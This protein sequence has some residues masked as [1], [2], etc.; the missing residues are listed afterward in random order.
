MSMI[1]W[2][3]ETPRVS[4][5]GNYFL[6]DQPIH[7]GCNSHD[8]N[9]SGSYYQFELDAVAITNRI[10]QE[11]KGIIAKKNAV[12]AI[13]P[14]SEQHALHYVLSND[15]CSPTT[16]IPCTI[17]REY[18][19]Q[20]IKDNNT[21]YYVDLYS[22]SADCQCKKGKLCDVCVKKY[23][24]LKDILKK[25]KD[26]YHALKNEGRLFSTKQ[27][28]QDS[29]SSIIEALIKPFED[30]D[31][32]L[33]T[34]LLL[35]HDKQGNTPLYYAYTKLPG[36]KKDFKLLLDRVKLL[37]NDQDKWNLLKEAHQHNETVVHAMVAYWQNLDYEIECFGTNLI[38]NAMT[39]T[40]GDGSTPFHA[41]LANP[42]PLSMIEAMCKLFSEP[43]PQEEKNCN[44]L[45]AVFCQNHQGLNPLHLL[46]QLDS[47][48]PDKND[49][50]FTEWLK[51][52]PIDFCEQKLM[53]KD[54]N[55]CTPLHYAIKSGNDVL[56]RK[57]LNLHN[58]PEDKNENQSVFYK[59]ITM[60]E[61]KY[62]ETA[63]HYA[64]RYGSR[65]TLNQ[66][67]EALGPKNLYDIRCRSNLY[68]FIPS[69]HHFSNFDF[70]TAINKHNHLF[71]CFDYFE[72][73]HFEHSWFN[74]KGYYND[75]I[76]D[77][78]NCFAAM[79]SALK[80][81][82][83][84]FLKPAT[85]DFTKEGCGLFFKDPYPGL[86]AALQHVTNKELEEFKAFIKEKS[87]STS[88]GS[89][90]YQ[91]KVAKILQDKLLSTD[92]NEKKDDSPSMAISTPVA[93]PSSAP[94]PYSPP[95]E[96]SVKSAPHFS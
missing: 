36:D 7:R 76:N 27:L 79:E 2:L 81:T 82:R 75:R 28:I 62:H 14:K 87:S 1:K 32:A 3:M 25:S 42:Q 16:D 61:D 86:R 77:F 41:V 51:I 22:K 5:L 60:I 73:N 29:K 9:F 78:C 91:C 83:P 68:K 21:R 48:N 63:L 58:A 90:L 89:D 70:T 80:N 45:D 19:T 24:S 53:E 37:K 38:R 96:T 66:I 57:I 67:V 20:S 43:S 23:E 26:I 94:P 8:I 59:T 92:Y 6:E 95:E 33:M 39:M 13:D 44:I 88:A 54:N 55:G 64:C 93:M 72:K 4:H 71:N 46:C 12:S 84:I 11:Y 69:H 31:T 50:I 30:D 18:V 52:M 34:Q 35:A 10:N 17:L 47:K 85:I 49:K 15:L 56:V 65:E 40:N 74:G